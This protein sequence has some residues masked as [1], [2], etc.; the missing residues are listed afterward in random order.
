MLAVM[1]TKTSDVNR[2]VLDFIVV[3]I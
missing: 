3:S 2:F 1:S